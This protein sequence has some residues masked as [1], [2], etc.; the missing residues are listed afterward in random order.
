MRRIDI[1]LPY[2]H[3]RKNISARGVVDAPKTAS[4]VRKTVLP[5]TA[6]VVVSEQLKSHDGERVWCTE[7][8]KPYTSNRVIAETVWYR[9]LDQAGIKRR[10]TPYKTRHSFISWMLKAGEP[11]LIVAHHVGHSDTQM[12]EKRY[13]RFI[14]DSAPKWYVDDPEKFIALKNSMKSIE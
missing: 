9:Q 11:I 10:L 2:V 12:I 14:P 13:A 3:V 4:G 8:G 7:D 6:Q 5:R 1:D